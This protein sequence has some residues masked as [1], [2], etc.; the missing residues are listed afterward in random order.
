MALPNLTGDIVLR[1]NSSAAFN[2]LI[3]NSQRANQALALTGDQTKRL[4][5]YLQQFGLAFDAATSRFS[6]LNSG[7]LLS[8]NEALKQLPAAA[9][10]GEKGN[11]GRCSH[12]QCLLPTRITPRITGA[13]H[14]GRTRT[15]R[16][17][18]RNSSRRAIRASS[19]ARV[20]GWIVS[21]SLTA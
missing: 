14:P 19:Q 15:G 10:S 2:S 9:R 13:S 1:D 16:R 20:A 18:P 21:G 5:E 3:A 17:T 4:Q 11:L 7:A 6:D 8:F 12:T